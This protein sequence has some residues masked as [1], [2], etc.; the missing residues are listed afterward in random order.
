M[1]KG[2]LKLPNCVDVTVKISPV[3]LSIL[4]GKSVGAETNDHVNV[5]NS[6]SS[7]ISISS[8]TTESSSAFSSIV[9][10]CSPSIAGV[11]L[12]SVTLIV[13]KA[14]SYIG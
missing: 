14:E 3:E 8:A 6:S 5:S 7:N 13:I 12:I 1:S 2:I 4:N 11:S 10:V 9:N